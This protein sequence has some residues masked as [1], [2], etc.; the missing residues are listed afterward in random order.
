MEMLRTPID[1]VTI[2]QD[3]HA[4]PH[5][6]QYAGHT[7]RIDAIHGYHRVR[8]GQATIYQW[9]VSAA[10]NVYVLEWNGE[11]LEAHLTAIDAPAGARR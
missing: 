7:Y 9:S 4:R 5:L 11:T 10:G 3:G 6:F 2:F 1:I 8:E